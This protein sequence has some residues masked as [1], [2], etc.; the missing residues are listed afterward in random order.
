MSSGSVEYVPK[1]FSPFLAENLPFLSR[2]VG[3]EGSRVSKVNTWYVSPRIC[4]QNDV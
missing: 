3:A 1:S 4:L 2:S